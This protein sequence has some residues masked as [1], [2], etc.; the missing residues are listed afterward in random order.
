MVKQVVKRVVKVV[1][2]TQSVVSKSMNFVQN[3]VFKHTENL[4]LLAA[5]WGLL[6]DKQRYI[7]TVRESDEVN[8]VVICD[9]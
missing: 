8:I 6:N 3:V 1:K 5:F 4:C 7:L 2:V 9:V